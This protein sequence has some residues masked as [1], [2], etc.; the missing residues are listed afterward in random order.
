MSVIKRMRKFVGENE[1][2]GE[3]SLDDLAKRIVVGLKPAIGE[4]PEAVDKTVDI[5]RQL[6]RKKEILKRAHRVAGT[7]AQAG[8]VARSIKKA[9]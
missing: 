5:L 4:G 9:V 7:A 8:K 3:L 2:P 1:A 6:I